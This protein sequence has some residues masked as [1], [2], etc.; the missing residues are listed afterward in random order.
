MCLLVPPTLADSRPS[1]VANLKA[2]SRVLTTPH[3]IHATLLDAMGLPDT[4]DYMVPG[5]DLPRAM[6][7]FQPV[8]NFIPFAINQSVVP[9]TYLDFLEVLSFFKGL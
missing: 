4:P 5:A 3:D 8:S 7:L 2:N 1:L 6:S 9:N